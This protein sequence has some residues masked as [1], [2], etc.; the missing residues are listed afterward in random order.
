MELQSSTTLHGMCT[1]V[2]G[3]ICRSEG[4]GLY[5]RKLSLFHGGAEDRM[6]ELLRERP[7]YSS[8]TAVISYNGHCIVVSTRHHV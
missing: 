7:E 6:R 5:Y 4:L 2:S 3:L 1:S 8:I